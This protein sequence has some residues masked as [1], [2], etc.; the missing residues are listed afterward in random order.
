[1]Q[2]QQNQQV[3]SSA[4][5]AAANNTVSAASV[6]P[7]P[8]SPP[9]TEPPVTPTEFDTKGLF[10]SLTG[11]DILDLPADTIGYLNSLGLEHGYP[12]F[13]WA[14][15]F[16]LEH[17]HVYSGWSWGTSIIA[18]AFALRIAM[19]FP[20]IFAQQSAAR[21]ARMQADPRAKEMIRLS[22]EAMAKGGD[23][24]LNQRS[25]FLRKMLKEEY[26]VKNSSFLWSFLQIPFTFGLFN[27]IRQMSAVPVPGLESAGFLWF[28]DLTSRDP[29]F[30][31]PALATGLMVSSMTV[32]FLFSFCINS[33]SSRQITH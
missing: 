33:L 5:E 24:E 20:H 18:T 1:M 25:A 27:V 17:I 29:Y 9:L 26:G 8:V 21:M 3:A 15:Q 11:Q 31:L 12:G 22:K 13:S 4:T 14:M 28:A 6:P 19:F 16:A 23:M 10:D 30:I 7:P 32:S 2:E